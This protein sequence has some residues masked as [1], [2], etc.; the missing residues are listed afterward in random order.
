MPRSRAR[1]VLWIVLG[2]YVALRLGL[3]A[4]PGYVLDVQQFKHWALL[5]ERDGIGG[6][7]A[8]PY[9]DYPPFYSWILWPI[10][11][12]YEALNPD[13][14]ALA[15]GRAAPALCYLLNPAV[16]WDTGHFGQPDSIHS[17]FVVAAFVAIGSK[18]AWTA[19]PLLALAG[20]M[21]PL[22][23]PFFPLLL[24][25]SLLLHGWR[26]TL[27]G[28]AAA[29]GVALALFA[30]ALV[31]LGPRMLALRM[32]HDVGVMGWTSV[33]AHDVWWLVGPWKNADA[34]W[35]GPVTP[36]QVG[37]ALVLAFVAAL[38]LRAWKLHRSRR[39]GLAREQGLALAGTLAF[40]FFMLSTHMHENHGFAAIP[41]LLAAL[42]AAPAGN[43][44][45]REL[46]W[47]VAAISLGVLVNLAAHDPLLVDRWPLSLGGPS[48]YVA[49]APGRTFTAGEYAA[50]WLGTAWNLLAFAALCAWTFGGGIVRLPWSGKGDPVTRTSSLPEPR[51]GPEAAPSRT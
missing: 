31:E 51:A 25:V 40:G 39:R 9:Y 23:L 22:G 13:A 5:A 4:T 10:G 8:T 21:K 17:F 20:L 32:T 49:D 6:V 48:D 35:L 33:L 42:A 11:R 19:W 38:A 47:L 44:A 46:A 7:Y 37:L 2:V 24:V 14:L 36:K 26:T 34:P 27:I 12:L 28:A 15:R 29:V 45:R 50:G 1:L 3:A 16:I 41:L 30:P 43:S 18:V